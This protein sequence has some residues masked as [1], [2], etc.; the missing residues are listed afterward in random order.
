MQKVPS[1]KANRIESRKGILSRKD[2][3]NKNSFYLQ[4]GKSPDYPPNKPAVVGSNGDMP[5]AGY[6]NKN[7]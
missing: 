7:S 4:K 3:I 2:S 1:S 6:F 5:V